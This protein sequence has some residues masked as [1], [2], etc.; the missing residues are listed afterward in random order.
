MPQTQESRETA[1]Q[2]A[3]VHLSTETHRHH[4]IAGS[5]DN[6]RRMDESYSWTN[7]KIDTKTTLMQTNRR[8]GG[9]T[10]IH[11]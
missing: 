11:M 7:R 1:K 8:A 10:R 3:M 5:I 6:D 4:K 9:Q 2:E